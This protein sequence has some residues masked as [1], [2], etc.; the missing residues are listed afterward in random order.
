MTEKRKKGLGM[1]K[2]KSQCFSR[3]ICT[4]VTGLWTDSS[5]TRKSMSFPPTCLRE[6]TQE[7]WGNHGW[8]LYE[9]DDWEKREQ[10][11]LPE[12]RCNTNATEFPLFDKSEERNFNNLWKSSSNCIRHFYESPTDRHCLWLY[13]FSLQVLDM[14]VSPL[15]DFLDGLKK[16]FFRLLDRQSKNQKWWLVKTKVILL[17]K[18]FQANLKW[19]FSADLTAFFSSQERHK[20]T[21]TFVFPS[22]HHSI[23]DI[24]KHFSNLGETKRNF[25]LEFQNSNSQKSER[26]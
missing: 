12:T 4:A 14:I 17:G 20:T 5:N 25:K 18:L 11:E 8:S 9:E 26:T 15:T 23:E 22:H 16:E 24:P 7:Q 21:K 2:C 6:S 13:T 10:P 1:G 3:E 19:T